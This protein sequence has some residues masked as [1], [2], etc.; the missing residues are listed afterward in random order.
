MKT[1][2]TH[3]GIFTLDEVEAVDC[4]DMAIGPGP[5]KGVDY[6]YLADTGNNLLDRSSGTI[7]RV[8]EPSLAP[9][10][11]PVLHS[12][13]E[14]DALP[15]SFPNGPLECETLMVD[16]KT[17]DLYLVSRDRDA[18]E[19]GVAM[20]FRYP[21]PQKPGDNFVLEQ[22][23]RLPAPVEIKGGDISPDGREILFRTHSMQRRVKCLL[24]QWDREKALG[25]I[26]NEE[27]EKVPAAFETQ[28]EAIAFSPDGRSYF[29][30]SE[31]FKAPIYR[32][33]R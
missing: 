13:D 27:P 11:P 10:G 28:G 7:Y 3:L 12:L 16:P 21:A 2:G 33:D 4:E 5:K 15:V 1:D 31:G 30:I 17:G 22:V 29:T 19:D 25:T 23:A 6:L 20:V 14:V 26:L 9:D 32:Y 8:P 18:G 24:W